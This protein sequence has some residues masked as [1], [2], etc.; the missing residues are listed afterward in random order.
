MPKRLRPAVAAAVVL[1]ALA[2]GCGQEREEPVLA[3][4]DAA[5][6][7]PTKQEFVKRA[8]ATCL[9]MVEAG[10]AEAATLKRHPDLAVKRLLDL[11]ARMIRELRA[12]EPPAGGEA[13]IGVLL[14]HLDRLQ[15][16]IRALETTDGEEALVPV[17]AIG[18]EMDAVARAAHSYGLFS[19]L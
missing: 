2:A 3:T 4:R 12:L 16:A 7:Q 1:T 5:T 15:A 6:R 13:Q 18:I 19:A 9:R 8:D 17:A 10:E 14:L 11:Q